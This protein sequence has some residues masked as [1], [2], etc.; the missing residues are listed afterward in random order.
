MAK[1]DNKRSRGQV[2][3]SRREL[4]QRHKQAVAALKAKREPI[5]PISHVEIAILATVFLAVLVIVAVPVR[6]YAQ[7][8]GEI[9]R[10]TASIAAKQKQKDDLSAQ[11]GE[12]QSD[13][14]IREQA[15]ARFGVIEP[16]ETAFRILDPA[17]GE[18]PQATKR[19]DPAALAG[20]W[21]SQ[22]WASISQEEAPSAVG[23]GHPPAPSDA[24]TTSRLPIEGQPLPTPA[25]EEPADQVP[26]P[27]GNPEVPPVDNAPA[28]APAPDAPAAQ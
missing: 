25:P 27:E 14:Y 23:I 26:A 19:E 20:P 10:V 12:L 24:E 17:L 4:N 3:V 15:R 6:N 28:P 5:R 16:G 1:G 9:A 11:L 18:N 13:D 8:R 2:P 7:Q 21:Y 22:L